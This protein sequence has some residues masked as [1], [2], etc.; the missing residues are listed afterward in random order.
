MT[1][2]FQPNAFQSDGF[3]VAGGVAGAYSLNC[4]TGSYLYSGGD[5]QLL[6]SGANVTNNNHPGVPRW[7]YVY[8]K[9]QFVRRVGK[10]L[11]VYEFI[12]PE[13]EAI[14]TPLEKRVT[15]VKRGRPAVPVASVPVAQIKAEAR[16]YPAQQQKIMRMFDQNQY[17]QILQAYAKLLIQQ[18][19]ED[20]E[21]LLHAL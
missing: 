3:Q 20:I 19:E 15:V 5:A 10:E 11:V 2:A 17:D 13:E 8:N 7:R 1:T 21:M 18:D 4:E 14:Q 12:E 9:N 6:W 16:Q